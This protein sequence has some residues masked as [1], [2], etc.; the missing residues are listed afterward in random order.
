MDSST[1]P[2][3]AANS[4]AHIIEHEAGHL[5]GFTH[6]NA[7][8]ETLEDFAYSGTVYWGARDIDW[9]LYDIH[10]P[11]PVNHHFIVMTFSGLAPSWEGIRTLER[12]CRTIAI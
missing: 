4:L 11:N 5:I 9:S 10:V 7:P 6:K 2:F 3:T 12:P 8:Q 1:R